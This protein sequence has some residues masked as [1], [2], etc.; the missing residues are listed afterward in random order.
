MVKMLKMLS[1]ISC[2]EQKRMNREAFIDQMLK[3]IIDF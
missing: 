1:D 2:D 3:I